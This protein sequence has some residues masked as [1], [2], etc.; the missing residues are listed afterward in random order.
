VGMP[1]PVLGLKFLPTDMD[2][3]EIF[4]QIQDVAVIIK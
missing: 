4:P 3:L 2:E 1:I